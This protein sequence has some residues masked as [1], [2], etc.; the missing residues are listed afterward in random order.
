[1]SYSKGLRQWAL[2]SLGV[3]AGNIVAVFSMS[4]GWLWR[5]DGRFLCKGKTKQTKVEL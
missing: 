1:M 2:I 5:V 4:D 3:V